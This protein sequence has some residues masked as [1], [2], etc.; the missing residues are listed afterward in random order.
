MAAVW[1]IEYDGTEQSAADWGLSSQ[2][3]IRT[4]DRQPTSVSFRMPALGPEDDIPI[5]FQGA[6]VIRQNRTWDAEAEEWSGTGYV[7]RGYQSTQRGHVDGRGSGV[8]LVFQDALWLLGNTVYQQEWKQW[9]SDGH[10]GWTEDVQYVSRAILFN[11]VDNPGVPQSIAWQMSQIATFAISAGISL[12]VGT[13]ELDTWFL[14]FHHIRAESCLDAMLKCLE[15]VPDAKL[16]IDGST[17]P[18]TLHCR[19]RASIAA[20]TPP[21]TTGPGPVT[22]PYRG[23]DAAGRLH[24]SS[25]LTPR[26]DLIPP[27]VVLQY[28]INNTVDGRAAPQWSVDAYPLGND[29]RDPFSMVVP[30][31]LTGVNVTYAKAQL[32][33]ETVACNGGTTASKRAWWASV[34]G[35]EQSELADTRV[36][37]Q[38]RSGNAVAIP[39]ATITD[40]DGNAVSLTTYPRRI[41]GGTAHEWMTTGGSPVVVKRAHIKARITSATYDVVGTT[42]A[43]TDTNGHIVGPAGTKELHVTV[44]L[45]NAPAG[46]TDFSTIDSLETGEAPVADLAEN[47]WTSRQT[48]DYDGSHEIIDPGLPDGTR[49]PLL[50]ILGHWNV[51]NLTGGK[52]AWETADLTIAGTEIDLV[53]NHQR[54]DIGPAKHLSPGDFNSLLQFFRGRRVYMN[55]SVR[56]TGYAS[57]GGEVDMPRGTPV[58]NTVP[59]VAL[60]NTLQTISYATENDPTTTFKGAVKSDAKAVGAILDATTPTPSGGATTTSIREVMPRE[61]SYCDAAGNLVYVVAMRSDPYTKA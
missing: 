25:D 2:P 37:L 33:C 36:R 38:D 8:S 51:L 15:P 59:G 32:D 16:W 35:G 13:I 44:L 3:L 27:A 9:I 10:G 50:Q 6:V 49:I 46:V 4:R 24:V 30:I 56:E 61:E 31:D 53:T 60:P 39:D 41:V 43:E 29:G 57:V 22:L 34:R 28:Q 26:Y 58:G 55:R 47:I 52:A 21:T 1:T 12:Q 45:T 23:S 17:S 42:P 5:P 14:P 7:F 19:T 20:E 40:D 48:L 11:D 18:P 54:I